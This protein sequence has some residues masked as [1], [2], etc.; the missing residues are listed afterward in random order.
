M[1][2]Y[3]LVEKLSKLSIEKNFVKRQLDTNYDVKRRTKFFNE[4]KRV[5]KEI[6]ETKFKLRLLKEIDT[7]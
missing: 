1:K 7:K 4:L 6:E 5:E 3:E 2:R